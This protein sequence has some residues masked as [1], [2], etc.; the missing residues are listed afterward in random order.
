MTPENIS[1][2]E[3]PDA[4]EEIPVYFEEKRILFNVWKSSDKQK[5]A[6]PSQNAG[7]NQFSVLMVIGMIEKSYQSKQYFNWPD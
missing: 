5:A 1:F 4:G 3:H 2:R 6:M 7:D